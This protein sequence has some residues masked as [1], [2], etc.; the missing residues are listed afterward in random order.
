MR[1]AG[2]STKPPLPAAAAAAVVPVPAGSAAAAAEPAT[3]EV[4]ERWLAAVGAL[5]L[6]SFVG[7]IVRIGLTQFNELQ[8][9][10]PATAPSFVFGSLYAEMLGCFVLGLVV[11]QRKVLQLRYGRA[12]RF[13][14][15]TGPFVKHGRPVGWKLAVDAGRGP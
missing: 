11:P 5:A 4:P 14:N 1:D 8:L 6:A 7:V 2:A 13:G 3:V 9:G 12:R 10:S 15:R